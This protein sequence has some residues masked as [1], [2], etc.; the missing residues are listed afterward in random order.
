MVSGFF[1]FIVCGKWLLIHGL[2]RDVPQLFMLVLGEGGTGKSVVIEAITESFAFFGQSHSLSKIA[3][4]GVA[5]THVNGSTLHTWAGIPV[6]AGNDD[7]WIGKAVAS[8]TKK[9]EERRVRMLATE[10]LLVDEVSM[11]NK[12]QLHC[13]DAMLRAERQRKHLAHADDSFGGVNVILFGDF[14][15]FPPIGAESVALYV[16]SGL[17]DAPPYKL[18]RQLFE[19]FRTVVILKEQMRCHDARWTELLH[20]LRTGDCTNSDID[21]LHGLILG[22]TELPIDERYQWDEA[23]L[24]TSRHAVRK[25]W[26]GRALQRL[27]E[28]TGR[29]RYTFPAEDIDKATNAYPTPAVRLAL[30]S[31]CDKDPHDVGGLKLESELSVVIGMRAMVSFNIATENDVANGSRGTVV[32]LV[33]DEREDRVVPNQIGEV[34]LRYPPVVIFFKL[35]VKPGYRPK[36]LFADLEPGIIPLTPLKCTIEGTTWN[37]RHYQVRHW[38][39]RFCILA[40][41]RWPLLLPCRFSVDST[42][43]PLLMLSRITNRRGRPLPQSSSTLLMILRRVNIPCHHSMHMWLSHEQREG[44]V[45]DYCGVLMNDSLPSIRRSICGRRCFFSSNVMLN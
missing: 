42:L 29:L 45:F 23:V 34:H 31:R 36:R 3:P 4:T 17:G 18:G 19:K 25:S 44:I 14:H 2:G 24:V 1:L 28:K 20:R 22:E 15:Q 5:A 10:Y 9:A 27:S 33:L 38:C 6:A 11:I 40:D 35:D 30:A 8:Q 43:L 7:R 37:L 32:G 16:P 39:H 13:L 41:I 12:K 26:N 21:L